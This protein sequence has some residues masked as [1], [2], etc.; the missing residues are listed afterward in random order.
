MGGKQD[1]AWWGRDPLQSVLEKRAGQPSGK[2][3]MP[4]FLQL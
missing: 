2:Q 4:I 1:E 3:K